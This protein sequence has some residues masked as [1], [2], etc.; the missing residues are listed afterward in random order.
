MKHTLR[1]SHISAFVEGKQILDD[2]T[3][4][5]CSGEI[6]AIM[7]PNGS[8]KSTLVNVIMANPVYQIGADTSTPSRKHNSELSKQSILLDSV[9]LTNEPTEKR[10]KSGLFL[11]FQSP[12]AISGVSVLNLL[13]TA[14]QEIHSEST[15]KKEN[16]DSQN[17]VLARRYVKSNESIGDFIA[18]V[19]KVAAFL[20]L[21]E[22]FLSRNI[23]DGFSGGERKKIEMLQALVLEP[24]F[25]MFDEID[26]GLDVD[27]LKIVAKAIKKLAD[28]GTGVIIVTHYQRILSYLKPDKVHVLVGGKI[29]KSASSSFAKQI[30]QKGY[31]QFIS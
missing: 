29:I 31:S 10:A 13:R 24:K 18:K 2:I 28:N 26:T 6:H 5:V 19:K 30:E 25:A 27:A 22:S 16:A 3:V 11:A 8:G 23:N 9:D 21:E 15:E 7:G 20:S 12:I 14:Y 1:A 4:T 17:P